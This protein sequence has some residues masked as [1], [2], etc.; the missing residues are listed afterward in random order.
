[1][2]KLLLLFLLVAGG[3]S[4]ASAWNYLVGSFNSWTNSA[5]YCLDNG[6]VAVY[7][8]AGSHTFKVKTDNDAW[9]GA[10]TATTIDKTTADI[11]FENPGNDVTLTVTTAGYYVFSTNWDSGLA[12][13]VRYPNT[14][15]YF[16]N[17][18]S[19]SK[20]YMHDGWWNGDNGA[21]NVNA[22]RGI[23]MTAGDNDIYSAYIPKES[24]YRVT[25]TPTNQVNVGE[26]DHGE[27]YTNFYGTNV[28]WNAAAFDAKK[29]LY[30]PTTTVGETLNDCSYYYGGAWI[31]YP[32]YTRSVTEGNWGTICLPFDFTVENADIY[33]ISTKV[34]DGS[35]NLKAINL[36]GVASP[37]AGKPYIFQAT[38]TGTLTAT[39]SGA[40]DGTAAAAN[41]MQGNLS[42]DAIAVP[43]DGTKY[44]IQGNK[45]R[46]VVS[47][48]DGVTC[49]Q[50]R[51][52]I[53][54]DEIGEAT[55]RSAFFIGSE[56]DDEATAIENLIPALN[57]GV[58]YDLQGRKVMNPAK[59]LYIVNG[60]K[61]IK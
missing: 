22:L 11:D 10:K 23:E 9:Y 35:G 40:Y 30:V 21:S 60:K 1:M 53:T 17:A 5:P 6:P 31:E 54:L 8:T 27:G 29:P 57:E 24:L 38:A 37:K 28:V 25:F 48:G 47:G 42:A 41:G 4:T 58:V 44:V 3:V 7:L 12:L 45:V 33:T 55:S 50:Y 15:V 2:K 34:L 52:Y 56:Y 39:Y 61:V 36:S 18:L 16:Y 51:A 59:G 49:G 46:K 19:W 26:S 13:T 32:T 14:T 43:N 20:V